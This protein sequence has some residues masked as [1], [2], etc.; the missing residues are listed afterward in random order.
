MEEGRSL[1]SVARVFGGYLERQAL[2]A[3]RTGAKCRGDMSLDDFEMVWAKLLLRLIWLI[4]SFVVLLEK[5]E[6]FPLLK[7]TLGDTCRCLSR[8]SL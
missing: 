7:S 6:S 5:G 8:V 1:R 3:G 4:V 2:R